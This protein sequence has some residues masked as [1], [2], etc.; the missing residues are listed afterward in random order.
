[1]KHIDKTLI[2]NELWAEDVQLFQNMDN[3]YISENERVFFETIQEK[4]MT[5]L[6]PCKELLIS[7]MKNADKVYLL[8]DQY[9][10][11]ILGQGIGVERKT[12]VH[13]MKLSDVLNVNMKD[14]EFLSDDITFLEWLRRIDYDG[15]MFDHNYAYL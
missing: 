11:F 6:A 7:E 15:V 13:T 2:E 1:M 4:M 10:E 5:E 3:H 12:E 8:R 9:D 14:Q